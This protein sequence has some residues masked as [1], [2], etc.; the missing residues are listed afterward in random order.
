MA[1]SVEI[2]EPGQKWSKE[3]GDFVENMLT[4]K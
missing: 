3:V 4:F 1:A 2:R